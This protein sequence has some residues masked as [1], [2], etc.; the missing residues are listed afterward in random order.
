MIPF[1]FHHLYYF[2][3]IAKTGSVSQA[4]K[5]LRLA[6][7]TLSAQLKQ[8]EGYLNFPLFKR[9]GRKLLLTEQGQ[10]MLD[11]ARDIFNLGREMLDAV[12]DRSKVGTTRIQ[13]GAPDF[14][15]K[16]FLNAFLLFIYRS[17][18]N[19]HISVK[20]DL[21]HVL[22][23]EL[24]AHLLDFVITDIPFQAAQEKRSFHSQLIASI[25]VVLCANTHLA[26]KIQK[27]PSQLKDT[28]VLM[29][30]SHS[31]VYQATQDYFI[32]Q[33]IS[34]QIIGEIQDIEV[35]R[36][37]VLSGIG[38][39]PLNLFTIQNAPTHEKLHVLGSIEKP[40]C[41]DNLYLISGIRKKP[42]PLT[43]KILEHFQ[44]R[45]TPV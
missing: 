19:V 1:N 45:T 4:A 20:E 11:Y 16:A 36:R 13:I 39:A 10:F 37:L 23:A 30:T 22:A 6:Q 42:H 18:P 7:P 8:F 21:P 26:K 5:D 14:I 35:V 44:L 34:P 17:N 24:K 27:K 29:P 40:I 2:Y 3:V 33:K 28:P 32:R 38:I 12:H 9:E 15:P 43:E 31:Q 25:P 41:F